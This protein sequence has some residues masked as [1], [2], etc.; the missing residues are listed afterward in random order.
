MCSCYAPGPTGRHEAQVPGRLLDPLAD[1]FR[2]DGI[3]EADIAEL[4][5]QFTIKQLRTGLPPILQGVIRASRNPTL[6][7]H[8]RLD[9]RMRVVAFE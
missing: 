8:G 1:T 4:A 7:R 9:V 5:Y 2:C 6:N 3:V